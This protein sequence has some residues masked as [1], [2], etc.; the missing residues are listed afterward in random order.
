MKILKIYPIIAAQT[1]LSMYETYSY[2]FPQ[3]GVSV[4]PVLREYL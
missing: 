4:L 3:T 1:L 2:N